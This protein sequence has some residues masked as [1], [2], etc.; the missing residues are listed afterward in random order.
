MTDRHE[1]AEPGAWAGNAAL[2]RLAPHARWVKPGDAA[3]A[4]TVTRTREV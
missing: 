4:W 1:W 2:S 3:A